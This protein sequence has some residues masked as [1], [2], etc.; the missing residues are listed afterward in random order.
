M[1]TKCKFPKKSELMV[2]RSDVNA[3]REKRRNKISEGAE[4][5][6]NHPMWEAS[7]VRPRDDPL[8]LLL[9]FLGFLLGTPKP[10]LVPCL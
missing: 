3:S 2:P 9:G 10:K 4:R 7:V 6:I 1:A 5:K 8:S